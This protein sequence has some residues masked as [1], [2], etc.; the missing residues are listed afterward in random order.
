MAM[1]LA[2]EAVDIDHEASLAR[3]G[4]QL[5]GALER[6]RQDAIELADM[7]EGA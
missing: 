2:D 7:P 4:A 6:H 5:P 3:A 1:D